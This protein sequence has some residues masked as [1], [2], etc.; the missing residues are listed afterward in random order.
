MD[1]TDKFGIPYLPLL[2]HPYF[3]PN[4]SLQQVHLVRMNMYKIAG[5]VANSVDPGQTPQDAAS[6]QGLH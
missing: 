5:R 2:S 6:D 4:A 3:L 1:K